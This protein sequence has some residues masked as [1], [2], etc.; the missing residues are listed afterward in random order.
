MPHGLPSVTTTSRPT[1]ARCFRTTCTDFTS[2]NVW[3]TANRKL[4]LYGGAA[5][6]DG[7]EDPEL[8][9]ITNDPLRGGDY[10]LLVPRSALNLNP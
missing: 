7:W 6:Q 9:V 5:D 8:Y 3:V 10:R 2:T 1:P 4:T